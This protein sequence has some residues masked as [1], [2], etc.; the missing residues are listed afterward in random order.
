MSERA[1]VEPPKFSKRLLRLFFSKDR[2]L[3]LLHDLEDV[4][5]VIADSKGIYS[6]RVWYHMQ[7]LKMIKGKLYNTLYWSGPMFYNYFKVTFRNI[8]RHK[9]YSFI[10]IFGLALGTACFIL[11]L[12]WIQERF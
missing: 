5:A 6:A 2:H 7:A 3:T 4:F 12:I 1:S 9:G 8:R 11:I 10:N